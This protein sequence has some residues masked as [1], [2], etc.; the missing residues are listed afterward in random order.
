[1]EIGKTEGERSN[2]FLNPQIEEQGDG[3]STLNWLGLPHQSEIRDGLDVYNMLPGDTNHS[4]I[5]F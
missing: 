3:K 2:I 4:S 1:M 5:Q